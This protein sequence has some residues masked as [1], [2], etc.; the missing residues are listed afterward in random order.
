MSSVDVKRVPEGYVVSR[1]FTNEPAAQRALD[2]LL[3][4]NEAAFVPVAKAISQAEFLAKHPEF[5][6]YDAHP[7]NL[8][9]ADE[10]S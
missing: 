10:G 4:V 1:V 3:S 7:L 5:Q 8:P 9:R 6:A 2:L